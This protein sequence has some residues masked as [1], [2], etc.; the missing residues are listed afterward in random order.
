MWMKNRRFQRLGGGALERF[1][2][3]LWSRL[4]FISLGSRKE[5]DIM[6]ILRRIHRQRRSL[7][8]TCFENQFLGC[9]RRL[10]MRAIMAM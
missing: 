6:A 9:A 7:L 4:Q 8:R 5:P 10:D 3:R 1:G 2:L